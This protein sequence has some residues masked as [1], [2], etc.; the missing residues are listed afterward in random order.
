MIL[1]IQL[2][3]IP[4][5]LQ[6]LH[7]LAKNYQ[8]MTQTGPFACRGSPLCASLLIFFFF[9]PPIRPGDNGAHGCYSPVV[10]VRLGFLL[11]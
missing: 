11:L 5:G 9:C 8:T 7:L 6:Q 3:Y 2:K 10:S 4:V 1:S